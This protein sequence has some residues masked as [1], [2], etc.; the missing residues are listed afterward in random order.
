[1][2]TVLSLGGLPMEQAAKYNN[3]AINAG[4]EE[5]MACE[6]KVILIAI[7]NTIRKAKDL[8]EAYEEV[9]MMANAEG[10]IAE[11]WNKETGE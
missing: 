4:S 11:K 10:V 1:M 7:L 8:R 6:T 9:A 2:N 3:M 5:S